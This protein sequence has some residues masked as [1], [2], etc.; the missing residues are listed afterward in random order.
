MRCVHGVVINYLLTTT[1]TP[2][3]P[4]STNKSLT[5]R[6]QEIED[7]M[8]ESMDLDSSWIDN[9][10]AEL[11]ANE[12]AM[13]FEKKPITDLKIN[14][15]YMNVDREITHVAEEMHELP[16]AGV[17][18]ESMIMNIIQRHQV[19]YHPNTPQTPAAFYNMESIMIYHYAGDTS[20]MA[21]AKQE[22]QYHNENENVVVVE[23]A[24]EYLKAY[25][26][27]LMYDVILPPCIP[28]FHSLS[29]MYILLIED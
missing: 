19:T 21:L 15:I 14:I 9:M 23:N 24:S 17:I 18:P 4:T 22:F 29:E 26:N 20:P 3:T 8:D 16:I 12:Y 1:T 6:M 13:F 28:F 27:L 10:E 25:N 5:Q 7:E 11:E 2:T